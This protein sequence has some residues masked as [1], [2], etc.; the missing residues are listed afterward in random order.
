L[1]NDTGGSGFGEIGND[2]VGVLGRN[3][4]HV[5]HARLRPAI[6]NFAMARATCGR[7]NIALRVGVRGSKCKTGK[8][9]APQDCLHHSR[10]T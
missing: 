4:H 1:L 7:A 5:G 8:T 3:T 6:I 10:L 2:G 9:G